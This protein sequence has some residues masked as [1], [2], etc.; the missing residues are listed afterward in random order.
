MSTVTKDVI[1]DL[2]P[3]YTSGEASADTRRL[4][5][6]FLATDP[7]LRGLAEGVADLEVPAA[8]IPTALEAI[9]LKTLD[10]TRRLLARKM[11]LFAISLFL[12]LLPMSFSVRNGQI[13]FLMARDQPWAALA[14]LAGALAG[15]AFFLSTCRRLSMA[16]MQPPPTR[17][18][19]LWWALTGALFGASITVMI[20][21][22]LGDVAW[23]LAIVPVCML[24]ALNLG[25]RSR[26]VRLPSDAMKVK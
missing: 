16:G 22:W 17:M 10:I 4:V 5:E 20:H 2:L 21:N 26:Q 15:W 23:R 12:S 8:P 24:L 11:W 3:V 14:S 1:R 6:E 19:R 25:A 9:E 13:V 18:A 7:E